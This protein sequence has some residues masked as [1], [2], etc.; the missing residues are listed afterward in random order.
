[1]SAST[2][3]APTASYSPVTGRCSATTGPTVALR[4]EN[5][6]KCRKKPRIGTLHAG[7][8][9]IDI[10]TDID[11]FEFSHRNM[12][13]N[14]EKSLNKTRSYFNSCNCKLILIHVNAGKSIPRYPRISERER[15]RFKNTESSTIRRCTKQATSPGVF[16][17]APPFWTV[18]SSYCSC[19]L[20]LPG[21]LCFLCFSISPVD[22]WRPCHITAARKTKDIAI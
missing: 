12:H 17:H 18:N 7:H 8:G 5:V 1:M 9:G 2:R 10:D 13:I 16:I 21:E 6:K 20:H 4:A 11:S 15:G 22:R 19:L 14:S 3:L